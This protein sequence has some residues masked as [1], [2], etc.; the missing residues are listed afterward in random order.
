LVSFA[1]HAAD[2]DPR[3][4]YQRRAAERYVV[5][6]QSLDRDRDGSVARVE[7]RGDLN[8]EPRFDD[9]DVNR[10]GVVT[11]AELQR[12]IEAEFSLSME[13]GPR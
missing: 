6:F 11:A 10:D 2:I 8:F 13:L 3:T 12:F 5:L 1:S 9:M 4:E 7:A